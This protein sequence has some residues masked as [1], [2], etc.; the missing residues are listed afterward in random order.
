MPRES[1]LLAHSSQAIF[2]L[3][4]RHL[5]KHAR[6]GV[7]RP[8]ARRSYVMAFDGNRSVSFTWHRE[9]PLCTEHRREER[10]TN[11]VLSHPMRPRG[12][13][14]KRSGGNVP[15]DHLT[16]VYLINREGNRSSLIRP[17][18]TIMSRIINKG[19]ARRES[20]ASGSAAHATVPFPR[21]APKPRCGWEE[22]RSDNRLGKGHF[23]ARSLNDAAQNRDR[24][25]YRRAAAR[26]LTTA[27]RTFQF[28]ARRSNKQSTPAARTSPGS[29][30]FKTRRLN[31]YNYST[32]VEY[33][34]ARRD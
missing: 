26:C 16:E 29:S 11:T 24:R 30:N 14:L 13:H 2:L 9:H 3:W 1:R 6:P 4:H 7:S 23:R 28:L 22:N 20:L 31:K 19:G 32:L 17:F 15:S 25:E 10:Q 21:L 34:G 8:P 27:L 12:L 33:P 5:K 18:A